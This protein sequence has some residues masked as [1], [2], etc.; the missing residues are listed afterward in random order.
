MENRTKLMTEIGYKKT[1][2]YHGF[3]IWKNSNNEQI[4]IDSKYKKVFKTCSL[5][6]K[7]LE[8]VIKIV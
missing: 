5:T 4:V 7:E 3:E 2:D 8:T 6:K 1:S